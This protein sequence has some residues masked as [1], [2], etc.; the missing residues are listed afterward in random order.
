[1]PSTPPNVVS[2]VLYS[3]TFVSDFHSSIH[4]SSIAL[5][6]FILRFVALPRW[7]NER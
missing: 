6:R 2:P 7:G 5:F 4:S 3:V 1:V